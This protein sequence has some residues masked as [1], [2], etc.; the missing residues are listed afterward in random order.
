MK[1]IFLSRLER[2]KSKPYVGPPKG[3]VFFFSTNS[4]LIIRQKKGRASLFNFSLFKFSTILNKY[5]Y[6]LFLEDNDDLFLLVPT[7]RRFE[8]L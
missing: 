6:S 8:R 2:K 4:L 3:R 5:F 1:V 7:L